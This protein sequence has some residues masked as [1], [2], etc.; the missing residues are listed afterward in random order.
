[1]YDFAL[2]SP[3][4]ASPMRSRCSST[5]RRASCS[6]A[7]RACS[8]SLKLRLAAAQ[9][10]WSTSPGSPELT[11]ISVD[12]DALVIGALVTHAEVA[13]SADVQAARS[14]RWPSSP[15]GSAIAQVRNRGTI[16]G[17]IAN[18]DPAAD[19]PAALLALGATIAT[20]Q[21]ARSRPT[22]SSQGCSRRR[23]SADEIITAVQLPGAGE[24]PATRSSRT[25]RRATRSSASS[26]PRPPA[27]CASR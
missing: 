25:R 24:A 15:A 10:R 14:R 21:R 16:G 18:N 6:P 11:G 2:P 20:D 26:S 13:R 22:T 19:Y 23:S 12:G 3:G 5:S 17:S 1:M 9:R 4:D 27:A 8:P 7:A